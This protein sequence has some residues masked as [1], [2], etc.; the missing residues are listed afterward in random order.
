MKTVVY[1]LS[2]QH[3]GHIQRP[4]GRKISMSEE[5][6]AERCMAGGG[7]SGLER[8]TGPEAGTCRSRS[9]VWS[10]I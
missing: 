7:T 8:Q 5:L 10:V 9:R 1:E 4:Y 3:E 2:R 6:N